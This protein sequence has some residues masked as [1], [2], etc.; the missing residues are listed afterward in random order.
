MTDDTPKIIPFGKY[1]GRLLDEVL[2]D[3]PGYLQWLTGQDWFRAKFNILHQVIINRG[4]E[5]EETPE[6]NAMQVRFLDADFCRRFVMWLYPNYRSEALQVLE[7]RRVHN[8]ALI[9]KLLAHETKRLSEATAKLIREKKVTQTSDTWYARHYAE[10]RENAARHVAFLSAL[11]P[12]L[13]QSVSELGYL[14]TEREF[15]HKGIDV[16]LQLTALSADHDEYPARTP[17]TLQWRSGDDY[18]RNMEYAS[19]R[20][21][22]E[23]KPVIGDDYPAV[24]RQMKA[25]GSNVLLLCD[26]VG[27]GATREQFIETFATADKRVV[28][29]RDVEAT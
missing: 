12:H 16:V 21:C 4:A 14:V 26:Y 15:E 24:L 19:P 11:E 9:Q 6:H 22:I 23:L 1:K 10:N 17:D 18:W 13:R 27:T 7:K 20:L 5:P 29:L 8:A 3:D 2:A 28:F 25:N